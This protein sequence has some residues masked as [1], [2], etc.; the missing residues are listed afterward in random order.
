M[1]VMFSTKNPMCYSLSDFIISSRLLFSAFWTLRLSRAMTILQIMRNRSPIVRQ[2]HIFFSVS[3]LHLIGGF[4][5]D[6]TPMGSGSGTQ[7]HTSWNALQNGGD[8]DD[9][10]AGIYERSRSRRIPTVTVDLEVTD[11]YDCIRDL[12]GAEEFPLWRIG[13][14]VCLS[15]KN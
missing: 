13:C 8:I 12:P 5:D 11:P 3:Q 4:I 1:N 2:I 15:L 9:F 7:Q 6:E 14:R 10:F